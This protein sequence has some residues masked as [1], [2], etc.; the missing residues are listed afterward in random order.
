MPDEIRYRT[1]VTGEGEASQRCF[2]PLVG[3]GGV[4]ITSSKGQEKEERTC[5]V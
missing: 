1:E 3:Q 2:E 4:D 5:T